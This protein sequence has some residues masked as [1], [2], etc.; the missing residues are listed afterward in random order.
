M[1]D[2]FFSYSSKDRERVRPVHDALSAEGFDVFWDQEIPPGR[3]WDEWIRRHLDAA[4]CT[5]VFWSEHSVKSD[6]VIHEAMVAKNA[7]KLIPVLLDPIEVNQF[8]MGHYTTQAIPWPAKDNTS[9]ALRRLTDEVEAKALRRWMRRRLAALEGQLQALKTVREHLEDQEASLYTRITELERQVELH[10]REKAHVKAA[11]D[12]AE[13]RLQDLHSSAETSPTSRVNELETSLRQK[14]EELFR[15]RAELKKERSELQKF[16]AS[17]RNISD[18]RDDP[19]HPIN[20]YS[21][22]L[23]SL[24]V[25]CL[26]CAIAYYFGGA[27]PFIQVMTFNSK[28]F[29]MQSSSNESLSKNLLITAFVIFILFSIFLISAGIF[30]RKRMIV[31]LGIMSLAIPAAMGGVFALIVYTFNITKPNSTPFGVGVGFAFAVALLILIKRRHA[32]LHGPKGRV[33]I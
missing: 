18:A 30:R 4:R 7:G 26:L 32:E 21:C 1:T 9:A 28:L 10:R 31:W 20:T 12:L 22:F 24:P 33:W 15:A 5:I 2:V 27:D 23:Y 19:M 14:D 13:E 11:L 16:T 29:E 17:R 8:P 25:A 3:N 6:N